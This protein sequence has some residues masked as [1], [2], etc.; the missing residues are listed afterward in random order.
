[1]L[2]K[3]FITIS[4]SIVTQI[5]NY[6]RCVLKIQCLNLKLKTDSNTVESCSNPSTKHTLFLVYGFQYLNT[7]KFYLNSHS[8]KA[9]KLAYKPNT[10]KVTNG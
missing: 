10:H 6:A 2:F 4:F 9:K 5:E 1:M 3:I 8:K 7:K